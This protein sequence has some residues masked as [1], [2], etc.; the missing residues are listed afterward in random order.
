VQKGRGSFACWKHLTQQ[1]GQLH[2]KKGKGEQ[3]RH[4]K[5]GVVWQFY[6]RFLAQV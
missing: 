5:I 4:I 1:W 3:M 2:R 6:L